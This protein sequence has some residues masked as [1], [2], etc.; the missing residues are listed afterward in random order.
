MLD[1]V[2]VTQV[3]GEVTRT[4]L[5][6]RSVNGDIGDLNAILDKGQSSGRSEHPDRLLDLTAAVRALALLL[7]TGHWTMTRSSTKRPTSPG[8]L[9]T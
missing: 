9:P 5:A 8:W 3:T 1:Q 2:A 6:V 7:R 4:G